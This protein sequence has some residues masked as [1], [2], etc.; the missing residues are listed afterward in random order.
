MK[1]LRTIVVAVVAAW[2]AGCSLLIDSRSNVTVYAPAFVRDQHGMRRQ[3]RTWQLVVGQ[4]Q[5]LAPLDGARILVVPTPG[6]IEYYKGARWRDAAPAMLQDL[7]LQA[8]RDLGGLTSAAAPSV[9]IRAD[10][11]LRSDLHAFQAEYRGAASPTVVVRI[12]FQLVRYD[13]TFVAGRTFEIEEPCRTSQMGGVF[14]A[15]QD[16]INRLLPDVV[17]W[18]IAEGDRQPSPN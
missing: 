13:G 15:F 18:S 11:L 4:P 9:G 10:Y 14:V 16:A 5:A 1:C 2:L 6:E 8:F 12:A 7:L 17:E 3:A